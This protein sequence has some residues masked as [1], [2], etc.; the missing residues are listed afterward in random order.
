MDMRAKANRP[1]SEQ[2]I[3]LIVGQALQALAYCHRNGLMHR[4]IKPENF[5]VKEPINEDGNNNQ[6]PTW[7]SKL[8][9]LI[10]FGSA[11]ELGEGQ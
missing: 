6:A 11:R 5:L 1:F 3:K 9:K 4:D 2:E 10:D 8:L 7:S